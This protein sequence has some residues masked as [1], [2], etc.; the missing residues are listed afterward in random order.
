[1]KRTKL[2]ERKLPSYSRGEEIMNMVTHIAGGG[3]GLA[4]AVG[5]ILLAVSAGSTCRILCTAVYAITLVMVYTM[6]SIYHGLP[7]CSGK[8]VLQILD[9]C[10]IYFLIAGTYT[11]IVVCAMAPSYPAIGWGLFGVQWLLVALAVTLTAIDMHKYR[12]FSKICYI[13]MGWCIIFFT[14]QAL[15]VL[16]DTGFG[17]LLAGGIVY[18]IGAVLFGLGSKIKWMHSVFHIFVFLG[19][20]L[21]MITIA[22]Y[23]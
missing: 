17:F 20:I 22:F 16:G 18:S 11:P 14:P 12:V 6:S 15:E 13:A 8:K 7:L 4:G 5:C 23:L 9:H 19:T 2:S 1:M 10:S 3:L 21:Q